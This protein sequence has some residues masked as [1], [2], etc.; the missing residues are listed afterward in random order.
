MRGCVSI[1]RVKEIKDIGSVVERCVRG[2]VS[3][4]RVKEIKDIGSVVERCV[5]GCLSIGRVKEIKDIGSVVERCVRGCLS[6]G[7]VKEI[8]DIGSVVE[9]CVRGCLDHHSSWL[10]HA[11]SRRL[12][13]P[14]FRGRSHLRV[15]QLSSRS[16]LFAPSHDRAG[17]QLYLYP[18]LLLDER[19]HIYIYI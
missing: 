19:K 2:C 16:W 15:T 9:R 8:K 12:L 11:S 14:G 10:L 7:R 13:T 4:E 5:R 18:I 17:N 1:E 3:I 6:I